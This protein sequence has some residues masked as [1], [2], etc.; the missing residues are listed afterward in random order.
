MNPGAGD[1]RLLRVARGA[2][3]A[4]GAGATALAVVLSSII[5]A[6]S[7]FYTLLTVSLFVPV[8][9]GLYVGRVRTPEAIAS[10]AAG[11]TVFAAVRLAAG[12]GGVA[13]L[14]PAMLGLGAALA[15]TLAVMA[16][17]RPAGDRKG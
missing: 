12:E 16:V 9:V 4:G 8:I 3:V 1:A 5:T 14:D 13:G 17:R 11:V 15:A 10:I 7:I 2:A 6:L